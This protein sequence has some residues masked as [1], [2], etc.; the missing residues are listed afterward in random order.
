MI[1]RRFFDE[2]IHITLQQAKE[3][4]KKLP[5]SFLYSPLYHEK[6]KLRLGSSIFSILT[7]KMK[8]EEETNRK[9]T[10]ET[11]VRNVMSASVV[12]EAH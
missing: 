11:F 8:V 9:R 10:E 2:K 5:L 4:E 7:T 6:R 12:L 3:I 1:S